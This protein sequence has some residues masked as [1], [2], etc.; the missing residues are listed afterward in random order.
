MEKNQEYI[1]SRC[2]NCGS[3]LKFLPGTHSLKCISCDSEFAIQSI[4]HG[5]LDELENDY[6]DALN[7]IKSCLGKIS[8]TISPTVI[9]PTAYTI[10]VLMV[11]I[12]L[13]F[14]L[15]P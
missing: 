14:F 7:K 5:T 2:P 6:E 8:K 3:D 4:G 1:N 15:A 12:T 10:A 11:L 13:S 9:I